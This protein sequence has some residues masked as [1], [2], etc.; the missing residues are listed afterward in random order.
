VKSLFLEKLKK[1]VDVAMSYVVTGHGEDGLTVGLG[2]LVVSSN[3]NDSMKYL[4][5]DSLFPKS[6]S[7]TSVPGRMCH[8]FHFM[9]K[10]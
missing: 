8:H 10:G 6:I 3:L 4:V 1:M 5:R 9:G 7:C 2:E